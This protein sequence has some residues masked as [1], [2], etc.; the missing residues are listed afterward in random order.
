ME[1][2]TRK[3]PYYVTVILLTIS[4][5]LSFGSPLFAQRPLPEQ[6]KQ[7]EVAFFESQISD[8]NK[9]FLNQLGANFKYLSQINNQALKMI[10]RLALIAELKH[11]KFIKGISKEAAS[12]I[13]TLTE[14]K[15][16]GRNLKRFIE[17]YLGGDNNLRSDF[18]KLLTHY[19]ELE[20]LESSFKNPFLEDMMTD[21]IHRYYSLCSESLS[22]P[23]PEI[24]AQII[25]ISEGL[26]NS[27]TKHR[28]GKLKKLLPK[29]ISFLEKS[30]IA[31]QDDLIDRL[32]YAQSNWGRNL[33]LKVLGL[34]QQQLVWNRDFSKSVLL[35]LESIPTPKKPDLPDLKVISI[36][37][38]SADTIEVGDEISVIIAIKNI[39]Q[40]TV[41]ASK[42]EITFPNGET[43]VIT[44]SRLQGGQTH[45]VTLR[46]RVKHS[47]RNEFI[48]KVNSNFRA[49]ESDTTNNITK[50]ALILQ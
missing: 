45:L 23:P 34:I 16:P 42:A 41:S 2:K 6:I 47:G 37:V 50:R 1:I 29:K 28:I 27:A 33:I 30:Y 5:F 10:D 38:A 14:R 15:K 21:G 26:A 40:L 11:S 39:G 24:L 22:Y 36:E 3:K 49:W 7:E 19:K 8:T 20:K 18:R 35:K 46:C 17:T 43:K 44:V 48:V 31:I 32:K 13:E 12:A 25:A 9:I 4:I